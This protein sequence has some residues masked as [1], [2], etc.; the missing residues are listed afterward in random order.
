VH[1]GSKTFPAVN[2]HPQTV[3]MRT[4]LKPLHVVQPEVC[5]SPSAAS[6]RRPA[7]LL[8][9]ICTTRSCASPIG[10]LLPQLSTSFPSTSCLLTSSPPSAFW[11]LAQACNTC[12]L[13][14]FRCAHVFLTGAQG[15]SFQV[16]GYQVRWLGWRF[17]VHMNALGLGSGT[18]QAWQN[19][20]LQG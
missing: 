12:H 14:Y 16:D 8:C 3:G 19:Q 13:F 6:S 15:P 17:Q 4:D 2:A 7:P 1:Y 5:R 20:L 11:S 18:I 9:H 10:W